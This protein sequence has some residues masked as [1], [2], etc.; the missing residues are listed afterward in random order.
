MSSKDF[1]DVIIERLVEKIE[2]DMKEDL[3]LDFLSKYTGYS[4]GHLPR[5]FKSRMGVPLGKYIRK[6]RLC[7]LATE[8]LDGR[9]RVIDIAM[10]YGFSSQ[11]SFARAFR[12]EY[13]MTPAEYIKNHEQN[14]V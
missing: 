4:V 10:D 1:H 8:L 13:G 6:R 2:T 14:K 5:L 7:H 3:S 9:M 11:Q 12:I